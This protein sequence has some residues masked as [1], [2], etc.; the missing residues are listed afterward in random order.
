MDNVFLSACKNG[1]KG[2]VEAFVKKGGIDFNKR[3][4]LGNTPL[5]Y[6]VARGARDIAKILL[7]KGADPS[8]ANNES[9][10]PLHAVSKSGNKEIMKL[11]IDAGA[12][13]NVTDKSGKSQGSPMIYRLHK[14]IYRLGVAQEVGYFLGNPRIC[15]RFVETVRKYRNKEAVRT[16]FS[17][18]SDSPYLVSVTLFTRFVL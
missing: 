11:L 4:T 10:T 18:F 8:L 15:S 2:I 5:F 1:Q 7:D 12:D 6:A 17:N 3:D 13:L 14:I 16:S 9:L